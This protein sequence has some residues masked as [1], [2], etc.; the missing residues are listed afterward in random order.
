MSL[1]V[2]F[3]N[4][5]KQAPVVGIKGYPYQIS[6]RD[7]MLNFNYLDQFPR[8]PGTGDLMYYDGG[9]WTLLKPPSGSGLH[10]LTHDG[11]YPSWTATE[12]C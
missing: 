2:D 6:A 10:V 9:G 5:V 7:L 11:A 3:E 12:E 4:K 1:P 8:S